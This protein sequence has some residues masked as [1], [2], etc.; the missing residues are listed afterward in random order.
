MVG[1]MAYAHDNLTLELK[2]YKGYGLIPSE[3]NE[4]GTRLVELED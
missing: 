1:H 3:V 4:L 2:A